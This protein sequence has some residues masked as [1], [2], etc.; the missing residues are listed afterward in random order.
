MNKILY[1]LTF[2][3]T[4]C[5]ARVCEEIKIIDKIIYVK[6]TDMTEIELNYK[7]KFS[8]IAS[9]LEIHKRN[10][11]TLE[12]TSYKLPCVIGNFEDIKIILE[13]LHKSHEI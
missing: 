10:D 9:N 2:L 1:T 6:M 13:K 7:Y 5:N 3:I 8:D 11:R 4:F 12:I